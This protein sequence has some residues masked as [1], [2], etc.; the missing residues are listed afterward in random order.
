MKYVIR[1]DY[2]DTFYMGNGLWTKEYPDA[3]QY[4]D[5]GIVMRIMDDMP[6]GKGIVA[7]ENYGMMDEKQ[8][9]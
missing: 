6:I 3:R 8:V 7:I 1:D 4:N 9:Y 2:W 5:I